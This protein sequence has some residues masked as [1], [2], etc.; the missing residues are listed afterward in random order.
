MPLS[1]PEILEPIRG[2]LRVAHGVLDVF[3]P[4]PSLQCTGVVTRIGKGK[5]AAMPEHV[6]VHREG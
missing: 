1:P 6:R 2:Q 4:K 3:V 5:A